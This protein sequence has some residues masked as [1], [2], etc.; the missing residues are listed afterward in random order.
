MAADKPDFTTDRPGGGGIPGS[1]ARV[2]A[3]LKEHGWE[4][5]LKVCCA[6]FEPR[7]LQA[8]HYRQLQL[9]HSL[10]IHVAANAADDSESNQT[11]THVPSPA[12]C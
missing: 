5:V 11:T 10:L 2:I 6:G 3:R 8:V 12:V 9:L 4:D 7:G 1:K